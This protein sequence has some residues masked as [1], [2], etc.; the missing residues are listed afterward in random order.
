M[1]NLLLIIVAFVLLIFCIRFYKE[2]S[3][4]IEAFE[5]HEA[6]IAETTECLDVGEW[7]CAEKNVRILLKETPNDQNLQLHLAG[8]LFEEERYEDCL[9]YIAGLGYTNK[10]LDYLQQKSK[11]LLKEIETLGIERSTHFRLEFEGRPSRNDV[12]EALSVLE[13][14]YDSLCRLFEFYPE[15]KIHLVLHQ[16]SAYQGVGPRPDWVGAVFDG[17][18]RV[19]VEMM[20]YPEVYRPALFHELTHAFVRAMTRQKL[21]LWVNEGIAQVVDASRTGLPKPPGAL[22]TLKMLS[23]PFIEQNNR[24]LVTR[25]YWYSQRM[26]EGMLKRNPNFVHF[27]TFLQNVRK[28]GVEKALED[29]YAVTAEQLLNEASL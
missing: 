3:K 6:L 26:V 28:V 11:S 2:R 19:P 16:T 7:N 14:A 29:G 13:V 21:P 9:N 23:D 18:L 20:R 17:K 22:P 4:E 8:I 24:E 5:Q 27:K 25:L 12:L 15:N 10:D 1:K